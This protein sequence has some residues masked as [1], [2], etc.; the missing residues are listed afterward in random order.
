MKRIPGLGRP[1]WV[2]ALALALS[3]YAAVDVAQGG[4][5]EPPLG[6]GAVQPATPMPSFKLPRLNGDLFDSSTLQGKVVIVRF[7]ATW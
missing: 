6:L 4:S 1:M 7:W 2:L 3:G 5:P